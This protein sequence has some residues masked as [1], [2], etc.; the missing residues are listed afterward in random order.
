MCGRKVMNVNGTI[1]NRKLCLIYVRYLDRKHGWLICGWENINERCINYKTWTHKHRWRIWRWTLKMCMKK[2]NYNCGFLKNIKIWTWTLKIYKV[3]IIITIN[4]NYYN[5]LFIDR[6][7]FS[8]IIWLPHNA[9]KPI[10]EEELSSYIRNPSLKK[11]TY[12]SFALTS[13]SNDRANS[14]AATNKE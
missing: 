2:V 1:A 4:C 12:K 14:M 8:E 13:F 9:H 5:K 10:F 6:K 7:A 3:K 11:K